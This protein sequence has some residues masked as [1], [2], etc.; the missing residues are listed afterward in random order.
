MVYGETLT[1]LILRQIQFA[2]KI[3]VSDKT[4][5]KE[6]LPCR[7]TSV[8]DLGLTRWVL[9]V[10][11]FVSEYKLSLLPRNT[12]IAPVF[13]KQDQKTLLAVTNTAAYWSL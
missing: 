10:S 12:L 7:F 3:W 6:T 11:A 8:Y 13:S 4:W 5:V 2:D 1:L 9:M